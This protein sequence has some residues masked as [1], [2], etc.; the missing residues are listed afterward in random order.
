MNQ[1]FK[2]DCPEIIPHLKFS[3]QRDCPHYGPYCKDAPLIECPQCSYYPRDEQASSY[4]YKYL[5]F[6]FF[7]L[8]LIIALGIL[9]YIISR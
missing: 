9:I 6:V 5:S 7:A 4:R 1:N 2:C 3:S 8:L